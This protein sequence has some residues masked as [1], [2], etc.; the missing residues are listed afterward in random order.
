MATIRFQ[1]L[2]ATQRG[3]D[4]PATEPLAADWGWLY[5][6]GGIA[7]IVTVV[8]IPVAIAAHLLWPPPPWAPGAAGD[9]FAYI[10]GNWLAGL[11]N[12]DALLAVSLVLSVPLYLAL[13]AALQQ[14]ARSAMVIATAVALL[15][16]ALH[17]VSITV[18]EL[19]AFSGAYAAAT[20]DA[21]RAS[22]LAAGEA[23]LA[24]YYGT[25][26]QVSYVLG[27]GAYILIGAVMLRGAVFGR[28]TAYLGILTGVAGFGFYLPAIG[29]FLS[30][31]VVLLIGAWNL[32]VART[33]FRL[34]RG[35]S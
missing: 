20:T 14:T 32:L 6:T 31:V 34:G 1:A 26:F 12:L 9:W 29:L 30:V 13:W 27:Y 35:A 21:A 28:A 5:T 15:G 7:A 11:L 24:A 8:L 4:L 25:A 2:A 16:T 33:L 18:L 19:L 17:L 23:A 3:L 22:Y 10:Q